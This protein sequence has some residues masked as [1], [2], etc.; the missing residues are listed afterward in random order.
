M[1]QYK[2]IKGILLTK[3]PLI[4]TTTNKIKRQDN[5]EQIKKE[6]F[7]NVSQLTK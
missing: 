1:P 4:K 2:A 6:E 3:D 7:L 5:L